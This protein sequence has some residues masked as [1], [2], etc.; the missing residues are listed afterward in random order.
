VCVWIGKAGGYR[1]RR[2]GAVRR[3]RRSR[4]REMPRWHN[5]LGRGERSGNI[6]SSTLRRYFGQIGPLKF[7]AAQGEKPS[8]GLQRKRVVDR[9]ET[10]WRPV[11][12]S[13]ILY[14]DLCVVDR[15]GA[16]DGLGAGASSTLRVGITLL[17]GL[18]GCSGERGRAR[19]VWSL[20]VTREVWMRE[21]Q[22]P[23][24]DSPALE[25]EDDDDKRR[26]RQTM[27]RMMRNSR[28]ALRRGGGG[29]V[30]QARHGIERH[31]ITK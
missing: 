27:I 4:H 13:S 16:H 18:F 2:R 7:L 6:G 8:N 30:R 26:Q 19:C 31:A 10:T 15:R 12:G 21:V 22:G 3:A 24:I 17:D 28:P 23:L 29:G 5:G 14:Y 25:K 9:V 11:V 1:S 20:L